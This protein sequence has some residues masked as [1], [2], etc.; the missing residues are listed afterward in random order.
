MSILLLILIHSL[1]PCNWEIDK[2]NDDKVLE[3]Y[4]RATPEV[5]L[6]Q[7]FHPTEHR[8]NP[9]G[10]SKSIYQGL[11][12]AALEPVWPPHN[13]HCHVEATHH[14]ET[15]YLGLLGSKYQVPT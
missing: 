4:Q 8:S 9:C 13:A 10:R 6:C 14:N 5:P 7:R 12:S 15:S 2:A 3:H 11:P 1:V